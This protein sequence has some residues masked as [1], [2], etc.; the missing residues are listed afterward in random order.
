MLPEGMLIVSFFTLFFIIGTIKKNNGLVDIAWGLGFVLVSW[1]TVLRG[2]PEFPTAKIVMAVLISF[3]GFRL[4]HHIFVRNV[5][6]PEDF[7]YA[8]FRKNWKKF[9]L[10]RSFLQLYLLQAALQFVIA[11]PMILPYKPAPTPNLLLFFVGLAIFGIG[12]FFESVGDSQLKN[13][14]SNPANKGKIMDQG[15]W[16]YTRHPNYFGEATI[17]WGI[18][19]IGISGGVSFVALLSPLTITFMLLFVSGV[20]MLEKA[21]KDQPGYAEYAQKTSIFLPLPPK[22]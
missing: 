4:A 17:W 8:N 2:L 16:R 14:I 12:F 20:P 6:K 19:L 18:M 11:L 13:F 15:L 5:G 3:W 9:F 7:R 10:I 21:M 1:F 22:K